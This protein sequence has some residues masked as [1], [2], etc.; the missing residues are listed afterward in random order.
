MTASETKRVRLIDVAERARV[1]RIV[2]GHV[3]LGSGGKT[4]RISPATADRVL[5]AARELD[6][7]PNLIAQHLRG[8]RTK[9]LAIFNDANQYTIH[10][11]RMRAIDR[12]ADRRG[13]RLMVSYLHRDREQVA[14]ELIRQ[15]DE[16]IGRGVEGVVLMR[17]FT[18]WP[19]RVVSRLE[20]IN[21][22]VCGIQPALAGACRVTVDLA[23]G[24]DQLVGHLVRTGRKRPVMVLHRRTLSKTNPRMSAFTAACRKF[25][26]GDKPVFWTP[27]L[28]VDTCDARMVRQHVDRLLDEQLR[29]GICDA[30]LANND[31]WGVQVIKSLLKR[32]IRIPE[33]IAVTGIDNVEIAAA[34]NPELTTIDQRND[35]FAMH[36]MDLMCRMIE[37]KPIAQAK[38]H[39]KIKPQ[40]VIR[41]SA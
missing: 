4:T 6:Y 11:E 21:L 30:I 7:R 24:V 9:T 22:V 10:Y 28:D 38:R 33:D 37:G 40:L 41:E 3:L 35:E 19:D 5:A 27:D 12:E 34:S 17:G 25:N 15:L 39:V 2:A 8:A 14:D 16:M 31:L 23:D 1:S 13:Y 36:V 32:G 26:L 18:D 29:P 20:Q